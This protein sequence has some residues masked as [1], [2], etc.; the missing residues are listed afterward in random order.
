MPSSNIK[1]ATIKIGNL[2]MGAQT[3]RF[4]Y[5]IS[6]LQ[7]PYANRQGSSTSL[8][9]IWL[10]CIKENGMSRSWLCSLSIEKA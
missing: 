2:L 5:S 6:I 7:T 9:S 8:V 3:L 10:L 1:P 4:S